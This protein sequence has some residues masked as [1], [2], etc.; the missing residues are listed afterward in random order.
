MK[1][2]LC[3]GDSNTWGLPPGEDG[4]YDWKTRWTGLLQSK[5]GDDYRVIEDGLPGRTTCFDDPFSPYRNGLKYLPLSL[6]THAPIDLLVIMLG[7]ND[8]KVTYNLGPFH[9]AQGAAELIKVA[10]KFETNI[11][12]ILL[13]SPPIMTPTTH[14]ENVITWAGGVEKSQALIDHYKNISQALGCHFFDASSVAKMSAIDGIHMDEDNHRA[15]ASGI[16][17]AVSKILF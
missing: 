14:E 10:Q 9:I 7:T 12:N 17:A 8:L 15:F 3:Y 4:R 6:E 11:P 1:T 5:L 2:I 16:Y 13:V